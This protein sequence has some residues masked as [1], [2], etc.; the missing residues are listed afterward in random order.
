MVTERPIA[1]VRLTAPATCARGSSARCQ[2]AVLDDR[3]Q[4]LAAVVPLRVD[5]LDPAGRPAEFSGFYGAKDGRV[6]LD[7]DLAGN[8]APGLW[9]LHVTELASGREADAYV[10]V[11]AAKP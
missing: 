1:Q 5:F 7:F 10:R 2:V 9:R 11:T 6:D 4:P 8:D 3:G